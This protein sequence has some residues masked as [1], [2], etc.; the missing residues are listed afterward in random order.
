MNKWRY[1]FYM[2]LHP[3]AGLNELK[4]NRTGLVRVAAAMLGAYFL[5]ELIVRK[6]TSFAFNPQGGE[7]VNVL[8]VLLVTVLPVL[9]FVLANWC[10][11]TLMAGEG[12]LSD[13]FVAVCFTLLPLTLMNLFIALVSNGLTLDEQAFI[14]LFQIIRTGWFAAYLFV[15][16]MIIQQ[17]SFL[18]TVGSICLTIAGMAVIL[19]LAVLVFSL[20]QQLYIFLGTIYNELSFRL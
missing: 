8:L 18:K 16:V 2:L 10:L 11:C 9:L 1:P 5:S 13:V 12:R 15:A 17:Y 3:F 19:F 7:R 6:G 14:T 20:F 4:A